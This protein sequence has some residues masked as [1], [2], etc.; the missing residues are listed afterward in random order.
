METPNKGQ[1][2]DYS[3]LKRMADAITKLEDDARKQSTNSNILNR[4]DSSETPVGTKDVS[5]VTRYKTIE[6]AADKTENLEFDFGGS[7]TTTPVVTA[8]VVA[9]GT[10]DAP[11]KT[12][13][14]LSNVTPSKAVVLVTSTDNKKKTVGINII[15]IGRH[16]LG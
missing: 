7:F 2:I 9:T 16:T 14:A 15:A 5:I 11:E 4:S 3:Y 12:T 8:T 10:S 1:P 6:V 13:I